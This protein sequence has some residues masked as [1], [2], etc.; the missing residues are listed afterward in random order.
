MGQEHYPI[1]IHLDTS[2]NLAHVY[3]HT[4]PDGVK[5]SAN[6]P[7]PHGRY[8]TTGPTILTLETAQATANMPTILEDMMS[9]SLTMGGMIELG[10]YQNVLSYLSQISNPALLDAANELI[11]GSQ[12]GLY[13]YRF[14]TYYSPSKQSSTPSF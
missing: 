9:M 6:V 4:S 5:I 11:V 10:D 1:P 14:R 3:M 8:E 12:V 2:G 13:L 7:N